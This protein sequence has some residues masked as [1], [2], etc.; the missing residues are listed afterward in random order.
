MKR[1]CFLAANNGKVL[2]ESKSVKY[3]WFSVEFYWLIYSEVI[4]WESMKSTFL[5][6]ET[7]TNW[8]RMTK[9]RFKKNI[10]HTN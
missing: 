9:L 8:A 5:S 6:V 4:Y 2:L 1:L 3:N 7:S 10:S